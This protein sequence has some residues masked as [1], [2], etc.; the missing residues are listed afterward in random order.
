MSRVGVV[1]TG[2]PAAGKTTLARSVAERLGLPCL[3]LDAV[4]EAIV[5][6]LP[7]E[8][9][10]D[11]FAVRTAAR[12]VVVRLAGE[13][14]RGCV[15]DAWINPTRDESDFTG[16][17]SGVP[18]TRWVELVCRVPVEVALARYAARERH[19]AHLPMDRG[20][21]ERVREAAPAIAPLGL[22]PHLDVDTSG[23]VA[24]DEV[25][26]WLR[27]QGVGG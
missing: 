14:A 21:E 16:A 3:S 10:Q 1:V 23:Q 11:R 27:E 8:H 25:E 13:Q 20:T 4:K 9:T 18:A 19:P 12:E 24:L 22:G 7:E 15:V 6:G 5:D 2:L 26:A 17:L